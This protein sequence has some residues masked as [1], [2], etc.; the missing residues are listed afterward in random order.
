[1]KSSRLLSAARVLASV[2]LCSLPGPVAGFLGTKPIVAEEKQDHHLLQVAS[3]FSL[4]ISSP[5]LRTTS[6]LQV[7][8]PFSLVMSPPVLLELKYFLYQNHLYL[9]GEP[10][11]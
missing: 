1:M 6:H 11:V 5:L 3:P 7:T 8:A 9:R 10:A 4:M 2:V